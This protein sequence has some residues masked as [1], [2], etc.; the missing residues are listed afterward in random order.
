MRM[1]CAGAF[2]S[3]ERDFLP[4][5]RRRY[6]LSSESAGELVR[7]AEHYVIQSRGMARLHLH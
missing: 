3:R 5:A 4:A 1:Y 6:Y 7:K 2:E